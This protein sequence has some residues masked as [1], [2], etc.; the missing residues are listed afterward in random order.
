MITD[1]KTCH[2][3]R[4]FDN[5]RDVLCH[6]GLFIMTDYRQKKTIIMQR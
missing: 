5:G 4:D 1:N 6:C 2:V 3:Y